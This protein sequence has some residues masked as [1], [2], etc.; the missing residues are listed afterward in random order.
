MLRSKLGLLGLCAVVFGV[1]A[2]SASSAQA[3]L[4]WLIL[5]SSEKNPTELKAELV[6]KPDSLYLQ[7]LTR[8][9]NGLRIEITCH[10]FSFNN[11]NLEAGGTLTTG[12]KV[13]FEECEVW[14]LNATTLALE[15][16]LECHP[17]SAGAGEGVIETNKGKGKLVLHTLAGGGSEVLTEIAPEVGTTFATILTEG[18][19]LPEENP[20]NG[21][22]FLK[23]CLGKSVT[24]EVEH[25]VQLGP[26]TSLWVGKDTVEHLE[27]TIHGSI[28]VRLGGSHLGLKWAAMDA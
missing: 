26:L 15:N 3:A 23:D 2:M 7:L 22:I 13:R 6:G 4:S 8:L 16:L 25:L 5:D 17:H 24:H 12:G 11:V 18:C 20:V 21:V 1:M 27:T 9:L 10:N 14:S 28:W 19:A